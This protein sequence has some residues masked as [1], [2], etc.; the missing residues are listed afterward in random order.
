MRITLAS[1]LVIICFVFNGCI[2]N[3][4]E[5]RIE[6]VFVSKSSYG[7]CVVIDS[8]KIRSN[9]PY[10][11]LDGVVLSDFPNTAEELRLTIRNVS[12]DSN[13]CNISFDYDTGI[14]PTFFFYAADSLVFFF[15]E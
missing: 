14:I 11:T 7:I 6:K 13:G 15:A 4:N 1:A 10:S 2:R 8:V 9:Y 5:T 12:S 3:K